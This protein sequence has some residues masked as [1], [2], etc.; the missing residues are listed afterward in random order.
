MLAAGIA[1]A[2]DFRSDRFTVGH[3]GD[4]TVDESRLA[5]VAQFQGVAEEESGAIGDDFGSHPAHG[6]N[7]RHSRVSIGAADQQQPLRRQVRHRCRNFDHASADGILPQ[8]GCERQFRW[9]AENRDFSH[10]A[11]GNVL[12]LARELQARRFSREQKIRPCRLLQSHDTKDLAIVSV[13]EHHPVAGHELR[14][15]M[16][17]I[18]RVRCRQKLVFLDASLPVPFGSLR[19]L[20]DSFAGIL[21]T[22]RG[23]VDHN[24]LDRKPGGGEQRRRRAGG[25]QGH[26]ARQREQRRSL[27]HRTDHG[28]PC[29]RP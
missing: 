24:G 15:H 22:R 29:Q 18:D 1:A 21:G 26:G 27:H 25:K 19:S 8:R 6:L 10:M 5:P 28:E 7:G 3:A 4:I 20:V 14:V 2:H 9:F 23:V 16:I 17:E 12:P 13:G 11:A